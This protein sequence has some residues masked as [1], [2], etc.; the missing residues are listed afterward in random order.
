MVL[1]GHSM[2][3]L[4]SRL[5]TIP[6]RG[7]V[8]KLVSEKPLDSVQADPEVLQRLEQCFFFDPSPSIRR[9]ITLGTPHRGSSFSN[10]TTQWLAAKIIRLPQKLLQSQQALFRDNAGL[11]PSRSLLRIDNSIDALAPNSPIFPVMLASPRPTWVK[12]H[13]VVGMAEYRGLL[14][15][16]VSGGDGVVKYPSAHVDDAT[17]EVVVPADHSGVH[18]HPLA[19]LEVRRILLDHL[20]E[21]R[22]FPASPPPAERTAAR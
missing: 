6:S 19:V 18:S 3:G 8:W 4:I 12:Y 5:Q 21:L 9:V 16:L 22:S 1:I 20:A 11:F 10:Q 2:G 13:N 7:E 14:G 17:S 15:A